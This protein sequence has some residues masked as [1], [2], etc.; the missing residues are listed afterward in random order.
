MAL[1]PWGCVLEGINGDGGVK[2]GGGGADLCQVSE[3]L[4]DLSQLRLR[5]RPWDPAEEEKGES[6]P[7]SLLGVPLPPAPPGWL[8]EGTS[9][10]RSWRYTLP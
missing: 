4:R 5:C 10:P 6:V 1:P 8:G 7:T 3:Q 9:R 2:G